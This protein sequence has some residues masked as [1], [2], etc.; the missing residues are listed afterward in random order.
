MNTRPRILAIEADPDR[1]RQ[2]AQLLRERVNA[3]IDLA[4]SASAAARA[5]AF[6]PPHLVV[7]TMLLPPSDDAQ[8]MAHLDT[9]DEASRPPVIVVP[10]L[11]EPDPPSVARRLLHRIGLRPLAPFPL[12]DVAAI[13]SRI[14]EALQETVPDS[15]PLPHLTQEPGRSRR[16][17]I[18]VRPP[19]SAPTWSAAIV[20]TPIVLPPKP[21]IAR[22]HRWDPAELPWVCSVKAPVGLEARVLNISRSGILIETGS[23]LVP[24]NLASVHLAGVGTALMVPARVVRSEVASVEVAGVKYRIA[25]SF[26]GRLDLIPDEAVPPGVTPPS[27][28]RTLAEVMARVFTEVDRG[29]RREDVTAMFERGVQQLAPGYDVKILETPAPTAGRDS[30]YFQVPVPAGSRAVLQ[31]SFDPGH[32]PAADD[33]QL[34][35]AAAAAAGL[36]MRDEHR[37]PDA[38]SE[39]TRRRNS[40]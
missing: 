19:A 18:A 10:P 28:P 31:V 30:I 34:M 13:G 38:A 27:P 33:F 6:R 37:R 7:A 1:R 20:E 2:L 9:I 22:A 23:K 21:I 26:T 16:G 35:K 32:R 11:H 8:M 17:A 4:E 36:V 3:D 15:P 14:Q 39:N 24:G 25:A 12:Y 5:I 29:L 40:W